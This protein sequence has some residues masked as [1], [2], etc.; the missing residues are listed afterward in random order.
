MGVDRFAGRNNFK[1]R[2]GTDQARQALGATGAGQQAKLD[3]RQAQARAGFSH[4]VAAG[5]GELQPTAQCQPT[6]GGDQR[7]V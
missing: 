4:T 2:S 5:H 6:D 3:F 7:F 1:R